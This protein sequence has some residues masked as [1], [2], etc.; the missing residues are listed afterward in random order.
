M[1]IFKKEADFEQAFIEV[2]IDK[3]WEREVLKN[4]TE[5]DLL[6]NWANILFENNRQRDRL[7]DVPL[8]NGEM[9][10]IMEQ[11]KEL[12]TLMPIS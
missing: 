9:Q 12:K 4:K 6:Q 7:N 5:A 11:I 1:T 3:G 10:Q 2:L 8:T